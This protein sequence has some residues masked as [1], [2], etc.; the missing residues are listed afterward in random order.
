MSKEHKSTE[1]SAHISRSKMRRYLYGQ[2]KETESAE[3]ETHLKHCKQ[4]SEAIIQYVED[5]E[6]ENYKVFLKKLRGTVIETVKT[7]GPRFST[8]QIKSMRAAAAVVVLFAFSFFAFENLI[9]K[10]FNLVAKQAQKE[11]DFKRNSVF[12]D[13]AQNEKVAKVA[14]KD[15]EDK[16]EKKLK[17]D[18]EEKQPTDASVTEAIPKKK[19][20]KKANFKK[21]VKQVASAQSTEANEVK[22][23]P[24]PKQ[25][26][27]TVSETPKVAQTIAKEE[28]KK[29]DVIKSDEGAAVEK[30]N[31]V[32]QLE[33]EES[34]EEEVTP[35]PVL[36]IQKLEKINL[37]EDA[38]KL[39]TE[40]PAPVIPSASVGQLR[41]R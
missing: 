25:P 16:E 10:D 6:P 31:P 8:V 5:E 19:P 11:E 28:E 27:I 29:Q 41:Q 24:A 35:Q 23:Q 9:E 21:E 22:E 14:T 34:N 38:D 7:K 26:K 36:P 39:S 18:A 37:K 2:L 40:K 20:V 3:V 32:A 12:P 1:F 4:C 30:V 13:D 17:V 15:Q 33:E